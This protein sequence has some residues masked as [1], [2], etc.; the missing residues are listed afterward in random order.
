MRG[1]ELA[2]IHPTSMLAGKAALAHVPIR[3]ANSRPLE[4]FAPATRETTSKG[5]RL[6]CPIKRG[7]H[8]NKRRPFAIN[9]FSSWSGDRPPCPRA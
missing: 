4:R 9:Q 1:G 5:G 8:K 2:A 7:P 3:V 6:D